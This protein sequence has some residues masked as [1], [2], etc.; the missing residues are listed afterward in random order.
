MAPYF[1]ANLLPSLNKVFFFLCDCLKSL[2]HLLLEKV[3][4]SNTVGQQTKDICS[5]ANQRFEE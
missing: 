1:S 2:R 5:E 4:H 3:Q